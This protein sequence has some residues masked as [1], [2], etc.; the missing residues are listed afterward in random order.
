MDASRGDDEP[1]VFNSVH[2]EGTL[3]DFGAKVPFT[4]MLEYVTDVVTMLI[5]WTGKNEYIIKIYY[6][7][8]VNHVME[9]VIHKVLEL[10]QGVG[11][12]HQHY[13]PLIGTISHL[14][15]CEPLMAFSNLNVVVAIVKV[16]F[17][18]NHGTV[19]VIEE[20]I[21]EGEGIVALLHD[22]IERTIVNAQAEPAIFIFCK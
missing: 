19:K 22:L 21:D 8:Q 1:E 16:N 9:R 4:K 7:E 17:G 12:T 14:E 2:M 20:F 11:C 6:D 10:R 15:C 13:E 5:R 18:I 3:Q